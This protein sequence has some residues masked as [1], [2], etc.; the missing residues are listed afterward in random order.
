MHHTSARARRAGRYGGRHRGEAARSNSVPAKPPDNTFI[1]GS[2]LL[3]NLST[4][5]LVG[6][7]GAAFT[8]GVAV[9]AW[10]VIAAAALVLMAL[11]FLP[12]YLRSGIATIPEFLEKR[13]NGT[14]RSLTMPCP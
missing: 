13:F 7:N 12:K 6:L 8:D 1:A 4:E 3:T 9:M 5:Q 14:T 2:L 11:Y 10:E